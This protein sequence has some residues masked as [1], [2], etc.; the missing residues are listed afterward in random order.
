MVPIILAIPMNTFQELF[1]KLGISSNVFLV[2]L[3]EIFLEFVP[4][5]FEDLSGHSIYDLF[6]NSF[7]DSFLD[8]YHNSF[9]KLYC[10]FP[11]N[12]LRELFLEFIK[13]FFLDVCPVLVC[14][15]FSQRRVSAGVS[16]PVI[17]SR[18]IF[19][20]FLAEFL[21]EMHPKFIPKFLQEFLIA[22]F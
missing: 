20:K 2:I 12:S 15:R 17:S 16:S 13:S 9:F 21:P 1:Q 11:Q 3:M 4:N 19:H 22:V 10:S 8:S 7:R 18:D 14:R 5:P 6:L